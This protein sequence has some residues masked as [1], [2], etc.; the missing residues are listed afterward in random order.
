MSDT[1][2]SP[3]VMGRAWQRVALGG[4]T[5]AL[6]TCYAVFPFSLMLPWTT[7]DADGYKSLGGI[8]GFLGLVSLYLGVLLTLVLLVT[9]LVVVLSR[10]D[11]SWLR[12]T[13]WVVAIWAVAPVAMPVYYVRHVLGRT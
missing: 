6:L 5:F 10:E 12:R 11:W 7:T 4:A 3:V 9:Y 8:G 1:S 2:A 13:C